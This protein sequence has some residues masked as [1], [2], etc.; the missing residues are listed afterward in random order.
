MLTHLFTFMFFYISLLSLLIA[1]QSEMSPSSP[2][3][4]PPLP[5]PP[6]CC[7]IFSPLPPPSGAIFVVTSSESL[8]W[9]KTLCSTHLVPPSSSSSSSSSSVAYH[10]LPCVILVVDCESFDGTSNRC[11]SLYMYTILHECTQCVIYVHV[12]M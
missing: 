4:L 9:L 7:S 6:P 12:Y 2:P 10:G 3:P 5:S 11:V 8:D 1:L